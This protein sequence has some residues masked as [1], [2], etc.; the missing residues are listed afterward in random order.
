MSKNKIEPAELIEPIELKLDFFINSPKKI[1]Q[2][3]KY[4]TLPN[5]R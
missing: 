4:K 2:S 5:K 3:N 1:F